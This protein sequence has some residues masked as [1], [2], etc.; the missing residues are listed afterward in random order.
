MRVG[1]HANAARTQRR[2]RSDSERNSSPLKKSAGCYV[3][4]MRRQNRDPSRGFASREEL[5]SELG[6]VEKRYDGVFQQADRWPEYRGV[7]VA[8]YLILASEPDT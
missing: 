6:E 5:C 1:A 2:K 4:W 8:T 7:I 3:A